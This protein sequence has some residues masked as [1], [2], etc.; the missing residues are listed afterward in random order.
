MKKRISYSFLKSLSKMSLARY[1]LKKAE[2]EAEKDLMRIGKKRISPT[3]IA[4]LKHEMLL[5][6]KE[7]PE[8]IKLESDM[9]NMKTDK[10]KK[11][12]IDNQKTFDKCVKNKLI[13]IPNKVWAEA[14]SIVDKVKKNPLWRKYGIDS[15]TEHK[16][17]GKFKDHRLIGY[18]DFVFDHG[19]TEFIGDIKFAPVDDKGIISG[20][21]DLQAYMYLMMS[22][23]KRYMIVEITTDLNVEVNSV[24]LHDT[25]IE[26]G[27]NLFE[28][29]VLKYEKE[30]AGEIPMVKP[31]FA[32]PWANNMASRI[33]NYMEK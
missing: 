6:S 33:K 20:C 24:I 3:Q 31:S 27:K 12:L 14:K 1:K 2:R 7:K 11:W 32:P 5:G 22:G 21:W 23:A 30:L 4:S 19:M 8:F 13:P 15:I 17:E 16:L 28:S 26:S 18:A 9:P 29:L 10:Y 25:W